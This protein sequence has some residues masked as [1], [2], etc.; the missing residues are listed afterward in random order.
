MYS[1]RPNEGNN[2]GNGYR[3]YNNNTDNVGNR[4]PS[5]DRQVGYRGP[6]QHDTRFRNPQASQFRPSNA[7][8]G[9][10]PARRRRDNHLD[11]ELRTNMNRL[12]LQDLQA[13][14]ERLT[15]ELDDMAEQIS[16]VTAENAEQGRVTS[17]NWIAAVNG[18]QRVK[19]N[20]LADVE[21]RIEYIQSASPQKKRNPAIERFIEI[22]KSK[23]DPDEYIDM[24][25][26]ASGF[27]T[28]EQ[29]AAFMEGVMD[30]L[31]PEQ[32]REFKEEIIQESYPEA[33]DAIQ[34]TPDVAANDSP[35]DG[36]GVFGL[37]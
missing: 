2:T 30:A 22:S 21:A 37:K 26:S 3:S 14:A 17:P 35:S 5:S 9:R 8:R 18:A 27:L 12:Q 11:D 4:A 28:E 16:K 19:T 34:E 29:Y 10:A 32:F 24:L 15:H 7:P 20:L 6:A 31:S 23:L 36:Q 1:P 13:A 25:E 33:F